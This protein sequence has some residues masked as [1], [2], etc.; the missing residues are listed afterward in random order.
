[1]ACNLPVWLFCQP[2]A[3]LNYSPAACKKALLPYT[4]HLTSSAASCKVQLGFNVSRLPC[5][6]SSHKL[7]SLSLAR[8]SSRLAPS[9]WS[10][11]LHRETKELGKSC[12]AAGAAERCEFRLAF[13]EARSLATGR[14]CRRHSTSSFLRPRLRG[15]PAVTV[16][17]RVQECHQLTE[18]PLWSRS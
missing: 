16:P 4:K 8:A 6:F 13:S 5:I 11:A 9:S 17:L 1:M 12:A 18:T 2:S 15:G 14:H 7:S 3:S 10:R